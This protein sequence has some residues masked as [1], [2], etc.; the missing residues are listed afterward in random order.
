MTYTDPDGEGTLEQNTMQLFESLDWTVADCYHE[1]YGKDG[2][3]GRETSAQVVLEARL[4]AAIAKLN[5]SL[6]STA[7]DLA[8]TEITKDRSVLSA[9]NANKEVYQLLK[10]GVKVTYRTA[11]DEEAVEVIKVID[12]ESPPRTTSSSPRNS[13]FPAITARSVPTCSAS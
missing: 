9:V 5:S 12:W 2:T 1:T 6:S 4:R 7:I 10:D 13:G 3:V 8:V 11:D